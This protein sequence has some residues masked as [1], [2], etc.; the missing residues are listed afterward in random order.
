[1]DDLKAGARKMM[2]VKC[3]RDNIEIYSIGNEKVIRM[4]EERFDIV[5]SATYIYDKMHFQFLSLAI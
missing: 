2:I 5:Y 1:M 3:L 4:T